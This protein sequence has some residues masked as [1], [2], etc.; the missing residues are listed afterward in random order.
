M[1]NTILVPLDGS[2]QAAA[3]LPLARTLASTTGGS[4][5]LVRVV[6]R[7]ALILGLDPYLLGIAREF[8]GMNVRSVVRH[9]APAQEILAAARDQSA[10]LIVMATHGR[11][12][13]Q[14][15]VVGSI[16]EQVLTRSPVPVVLTRPGGKHVTHLQTLLVP[17]DGTAGAALALSTAS[18]LARASGAQL[19][20]V[21][22]VGR[23][24]TSPTIEAV[25]EQIDA[26]LIVMSTHARTGPARAMLG[27]TADTLVRTA[28]RPVLLIR[29]PRAALDVESDRP[30][31][32]AVASII[33]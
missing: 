17:T 16:A 15:T 9:G 5:V 28:K 12:G 33:A 3:A 1:F 13:L 4:V 22:V 31:Q 10:D 23:H 7:S 20:L 8:D 29:R 30:S 27:S 24:R 11:S 32:T 6:P 26:D 2:P 18:E 14:R 25:A 21:E 19:V